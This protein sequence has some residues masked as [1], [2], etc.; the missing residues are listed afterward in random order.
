MIL[1]AKEYAE[2]PI[3]EGKKIEAREIHNQIPPRRGVVA[4]DVRRLS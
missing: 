4:V 2:Q 1:I 3:G